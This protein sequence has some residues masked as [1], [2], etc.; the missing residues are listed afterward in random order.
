MI[1]H[2]SKVK[3][4]FLDRLTEEFASMP[5]IVPKLLPLPV[6]P[7]ILPSHQCC[8]CIKVFEHEHS[9]RTHLLSDHLNHDTE[10]SKFPN[11]EYFGGKINT[12]KPNAIVGPVQDVIVNNTELKVC[13]MN[14]NSIASSLK[15]STTKLGIEESKAD[16]IIMAES[17]L[18][19][20]H[21]EFKVRGY[22]TVSNLTRKSGAGGL[23]IMAKDTIKMHSITKRNVLDEIQVIT[24]KFGDITFI[25]VYRSPSYGT[26]SPR[27]H[28]KSL[29]NHLD[30]EIDKLK[31]AQYIL[32]GD[33]N[34][35]TL[36][37]N[38]FE[39]P[40]NSTD[41]DNEGDTYDEENLSIDQMWADFYSRR[42]LD[43]WVQDPT[44]HRYNSTTK[45]HTETMTDLVMTP[46][47]QS[48]HKIR[49]DRELFQGKY[50]HY[51]VVFTLNT[52]YTT[53]ETPRL[54]RDKS[55]RNWLKF[56]EL[57]ISYRIFETA[58]R[59]TTDRM[60][61]YIIDKI[62]EAYN[63][64]IPLIKV[65]PPPP[66]GHLHR[67][68]RKY[69]K[70]ATR[71]RKIFRTLMPGSDGH[72]SV[73]TKLKILE[74]CV[75]AMIKN[76]RVQKQIRQL[77][78]SKNDH[79]NLYAHIK[80]VK[81]L[82][83]CIGP[84]LNV[85]G[86]RCSSDPEMSTS[87]GDLL[88][89]QLKPTHT[90]KT[91]INWDIH[92]PDSPDDK[93][94]SLYITSDMVKYQI[95]KSKRGAA[96]GPDGIP[97]EAISIAKDILAGPLEGLYNLVIQT[98]SVPKCFRTARVKMLYKKG[99]K[100]DMLN[101]RPLS[102]SNHV[103]KVWERLVNERLMDHFETN[104]IFSEGQHGFRRSRGTTTNLILLWETAMK[105]IENKGSHVELWNY[106]LTKAFDML[107]HR[108]VLELLHQS[109][110]YGQ[111]G[112][113][114]ENWLTKRTQTVE[115]G[116][117]RSDEKPVGRSCVQGSVLG[118]TLWLLYIQ[119]LTNIL[120][121]MGVEYK[122]YADDIS[123]V[124]RISTEQEKVK[125]EGILKVLQDWAKNYCMRWSPLKTQRMVFKYQNCRESHPPYEMT[126]GGK[127]IQPL[128]STCISLGIIFDKNCTFTSQIRKVC[129]QIRALTSLV[130][131]EIANITPALLEKYYQV[132]IIPNLIYCS[133]LWNP[134]NEAQLR[135]IE[136]AV[137][138]FW[139]LSKNGPPKDHIKP[140]LLLLMIDLNYVK[141]I[142]D[143]NHVLDFDEIFETEKHRP[144]RVDTDDKLPM[145]NKR[146]NVSKK[147][148]SYR[149]RTYWNLIPKSIRH[150]TYSGFKT[151]AKEFILENSRLF[152]NQGN[153]DKE[154]SHKIFEP[155][156]PLSKTKGADAGFKEAF[157]DKIKA[158]RVKY[159][160]KYCQQSPTV[161][162]FGR[163][164]TNHTKNSH[165][166]EPSMDPK[167]KK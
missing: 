152:L 160:E 78:K 126:F 103:G 8:K 54:R 133:Q 148:F 21:T 72:M 115:I 40:S 99:E 38:N 112:R 7:I 79:T 131:Q 164:K 76:D 162:D 26:T 96:G 111:L 61:E 143:G 41:C 80:Q 46:T 89:E 62:M 102:M 132:Y 71:L 93:I 139:R 90:W 158:L 130:K 28:H 20:K 137:E 105:K 9:L 114:I 123:I 74:K 97:M 59:D 95:T 14:V 156:A 149:T 107:D 150:M 5:Y 141:I 83:S 53:N 129:N 58:P 25:S 154:V 70:K 55:S 127:V 166:K 23:V 19:D 106:D 36:A 110:V 77:E 144:D 84:I 63:E 22:W 66:G 121:K 82:T 16:L 31:G 60:A 109:G 135:E 157:N 100:S 34:L 81:S 50:D 44:F 1:V 117:S 108:K 153:K 142:W 159:R 11:F 151:K 75:D 124:Q 35:S 88:G 30:K 136:N 120:D 91:G 85:N 37:A 161:A 33:F 87:F 165:G 52:C 125:F 119:S 116:T 69:I 104:K 29:I 18:G 24:C 98:G 57:L 47:N 42:Y 67:E 146:L 94:K 6:G 49:V 3:A 86:V 128:D 122:A 51:A 134:A 43:Q 167:R 145:I 101:Y 2:P 65:K 10:M 27:V 39:P 48:I 155:N 68:T 12:K 73:W 140:R 113:A 64:A 13:F 45:V 4:K 92:H 15:R 138:R 17:K 163:P 147:M 118:P 32:V 56:Y